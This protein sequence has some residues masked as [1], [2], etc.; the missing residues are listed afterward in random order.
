MIS[1]VP[2]LISSVR[3]HV[4]GCK[5]ISGALEQIVPSHQYWRYKEMWQN[6]LRNVVFAVILMEYLTSGELASLELVRDTL[7]SKSGLHL[8]DIWLDS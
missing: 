5:T 2:D 7:G 8:A 6:S 3:P 1:L 4:D